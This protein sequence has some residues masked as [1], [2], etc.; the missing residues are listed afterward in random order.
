[1][2]CL[3]TIYQFFEGQK[4]LEDDD[5]HLRCAQAIAHESALED[6]QPPTPQALVNAL[7]SLSLRIMEIV[8]AKSPLTSLLWRVQTDIPPELRELVFSF[9]LDSPGGS[10]LFLEKS[11]DV[12]RDLGS[13]PEKRKRI[14]SC[15]SALFARW[16]GNEQQPI[17]AGLYED[18]VH[19]S[20]R[21][22]ADDS[23]W[24]FIVLQWDDSHITSIKL[25]AHEAELLLASTNESSSWQIL[26]RP[27]SG[28]LWVTLKVNM[29]SHVI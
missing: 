29:I 3:A 14:I 9:M 1:M 15:H 2:R 13:W 24:A 20:Q 8:S 17:L 28:L 10:F 5:W 27:C 26:Q 21:I 6:R 23:S 25:V 4:L 18:K 22:D 11:L 19:D 16:S 7:E 12:L